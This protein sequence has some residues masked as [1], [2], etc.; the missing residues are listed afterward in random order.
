M[1]HWQE[2]ISRCYVEVSYLTER[3]ITA[4]NMPFLRGSGLYEIKFIKAA[5]V[6]GGNGVIFMEIEQVR[7]GHLQNQ[8]ELCGA[9]QVLIHS[10]P[11]N[12]SSHLAGKYLGRVMQMCDFPG[13]MSYQRG[14]TND[15]CPA[16]DHNDVALYEELK[17]VQMRLDASPFEE[18]MGEVR[19]QLL[20]LSLAFNDTSCACLI[21]Q[22]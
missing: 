12:D 20:D 2:L 4:F 6:E 17:R 21:I 10:F 3:I 14:Y 5:Y 9:R 11:S 22:R 8:L 19:H 1:L 15:I 13:K 7:R 18:R 16:L